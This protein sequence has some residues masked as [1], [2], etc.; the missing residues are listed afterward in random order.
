MLSVTFFRAAILW[1]FGRLCDPREVARV[2]FDYTNRIPRQHRQLLA[3]R[4]AEAVI[5]AE[6]NGEVQLIQEIKWDHR[7]ALNAMQLVT[8][9]VFE[10]AVQSPAGLLELRELSQQVAAD[11]ARLAAETGRCVDSLFAQREL[12]QGEIELLLSQAGDALRGER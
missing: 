5:R 11:H 9:F 1:K 4:E 6:L 10:E 8:R 7:Q 12:Y 3:M 2:L